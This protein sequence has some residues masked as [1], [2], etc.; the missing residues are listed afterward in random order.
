MTPSGVVS[1]MST[2][3]TSQPSPLVFGFPASTVY[4]MPVVSEKK[5]RLFWMLST[6]S[7]DVQPA[8]D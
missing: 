7:F 2:P 4:W 3:P 6:K 8:G 5:A 1:V